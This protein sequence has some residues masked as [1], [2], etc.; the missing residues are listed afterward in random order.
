MF[1]PPRFV[2]IDDREQDLNAIV[3]AF[4]RLGT[5]CCGLHYKAEEDVD[6]SQ[7]RGVRALFMDLHLNEGSAPGDHRQHHATIAGIL[8]DHIAEDGGPF[9]LILWTQKENE[10]AGLI[11]Y[12]DQHLDVEKPWAR[13]VATLSLSKTAFIVDGKFDVDKADDLKAAVLQR[14]DAV[15]Q[16]A[17]LLSWEGDVVDAASATLR[18]VT[19]RIAIADRNHEKYGKAL[20]KMLSQLARAAVGRVHAKA[21]PRAAMNA[22]LSPILSDRVIHTPSARSSNLW[23][24]ALTK[25]GVNSL[26]SISPEDQGATNRMLHV[27]LTSGEPGMKSSDWG[28]VSRVP[29]EA[30]NVV[31][32]LG[33]S[34]EDLLQKVFKVEASASDRVVPLL[35]R[36]GATC[37]HA[38]ARVGPVPYFVGL[39]IPHDLAE[40][41]V[42]V[43]KAEWL[44]PILELQGFTGPQRLA[45]NARFPQTLSPSA[46]GLLTPLFRLREQLLM[47]M[48]AETGAYQTRPGIVALLSKG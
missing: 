20:D 32:H 29:W 30:E 1:T 41:R 28:V 37:D 12:L 42:E 26:G 4:R 45:V 33:I 13:P 15:P 40:V 3:Q 8:E 16:I 22:V 38:Q 25:V 34:Y 44:S 23:S 46:A 11:K 31:D 39:A 5:L 14:L 6:G 21:D 35:V 47:E 36:A 19:D 17:A 43:P 24:N 10:V 27:A 18:A 7:L 2:V 9:V 48:I